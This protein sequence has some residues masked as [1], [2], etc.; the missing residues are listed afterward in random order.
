MKK[1]ATR[2][3]SFMTV[4]ALVILCL[5]GCGKGDKSNTENNVATMNESENFNKEGFPIVNDQVTLTVLTTRWGNMGDSFAQNQFLKDLEANTNVKIEWQVQSLSDWS[6]QKGILLASGELPDIIIGNQTFGDSDIITNLNMFLPLNDLV[7]EYMPNYKNALQEMPAMKKVVTFTD[8]EMYSMGKNLP[9]RPTVC[10]QPIIN[11]VWLDNLGLKEPTNTDELFTVLKAFKE[12][13]ANGNGDPNDEIPITGQKGISMDLINP[14]GITDLYGSNMLVNED[15]SLVYYPTSDQ[16]KE[17]LKWLRKLY[18]EGIIDQEAFTQ[19]DTMEL[20]KN[21]DPNVARVGFSYNWIPDAV[22]GQWSGEYIAIA[23]I[24][25]PDGKRYASGDT[26]GISGVGR[27][28]ALISVNCKYPEIAARWLDQ[29][30]TGEASIQN[31]WGA[32]GTVISKNDDGKY[33]LNDPPEGTSADSWYWDQSLRDFGPKYVSAEFQENIELS[34]ES[35]DGLKLELSKLGEDYITKPYPNVFLTLE[36]LDEIAT[37]ETD[38]KKYV[39]VS[40]ATWI[41]EGGIDEG[42]NEYVEQL[43]A[44]GL[45]RLIE[46]RTTAFENYN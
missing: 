9:M 17:G 34:P 25:G 20:G 13:D 38:I 23:P 10:G 28:E 37:L 44:M 18:A 24:A 41:T 35:G 7:D 42:W 46:I 39:E 8:G 36:E 5:G 12:Q 45:D 11:K 15:D 1:K 29:F 33:V 43:E 16:Y 14:F 3:F 32:I 2:V 27:N 30:Y 21:Q 31:F 22:Y 4:L 19:D 6:E 40:R 26:N